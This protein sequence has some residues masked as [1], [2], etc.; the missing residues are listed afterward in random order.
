MSFESARPITAESTSQQYRDNRRPKARYSPGSRARQTV[1]ISE[2]TRV[3]VATQRLFTPEARSRSY[4][5]HGQAS[6]KTM[7]GQ[8]LE[9]YA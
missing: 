5:P 1:N 8:F 9:S 2:D 3:R 6:S 7:I 4:S